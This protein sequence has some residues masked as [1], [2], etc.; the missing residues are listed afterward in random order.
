MSFG[1]GS[2]DF[3]RVVDVDA[4]VTTTDEYRVLRDEKTTLA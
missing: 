2:V 3:E 4:D 1:L